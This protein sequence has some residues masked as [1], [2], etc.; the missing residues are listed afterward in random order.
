VAEVGN[1]REWSY[2]HA[3][4]LLCV[5]VSIKVWI[6][7]FCLSCLYNGAGDPETVSQKAGGLGS[8]GALRWTGNLQSTNLV[9][10]LNL[11]G[12]LVGNLCN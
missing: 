10:Q 4:V 7:Y 2:G 12:S 6:H 11:K 8:W 5:L 3:L 1:K 9:Q